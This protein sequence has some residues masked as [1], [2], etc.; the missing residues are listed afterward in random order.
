M[1]KKIDHLILLRGLLREVGHWGDFK[2]QMAQALPKIE[3]HTVDL[4]GIGEFA[5]VS[6][7]FSISGMARFVHEK[8]ES[9][10][11]EGRIGLFAVSLGAMTALQMKADFSEAYGPV[12]AIN[13]SSTLSPR[14]KRLRWERWRAFLTVVSEWNVSKREEK[15]IPMVVNSPEGRKAAGEVWVRI[16]KEK[17]VHPLTAIAQLKS[18]MGFLPA[19][20]LKDSKEILLI[21][22]LGDLLVD[23][24]C[25]EL[26]HKRYNWEHHIHP[27]GGHDLAWDDS[28]WLLSEAQ[29]F[30][31]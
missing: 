7:P 1:E 31:T 30:F 21:S 2:N 23:P 6:P 8:I 19:D 24:S 29:S 11:L 5:R 26:L 27:W 17:K 28:D 14:H 18:A 4:P 3:V 15:I 10:N 25:S 22:S 12:I 9:K 16:V 13:T 20:S